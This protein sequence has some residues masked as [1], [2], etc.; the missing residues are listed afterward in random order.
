MDLISHRTQYR[1]DGIFSEVTDADGPVMVALEHAYQDDQGNYEPKIPPGVYDC[2]RGMHQL[3]DM[4]APF[5]TFEITGVA[6]HTGLLF[7]AGNFDK[8]SEGCMLC[9][10]AIADDEDGEMVTNSRAAFEKFMAL[11]DGVDS[12]Q[13]EVRA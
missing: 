13:L 10:E 3:A 2:V 4:D 8:D 12:F 7:H 11:Q 9:G 6:G 5:E 1:P